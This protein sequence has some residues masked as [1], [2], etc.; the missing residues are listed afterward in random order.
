VGKEKRKRKNNHGGHG[1]R[2]YRK[3]KRKKK[4]NH[5]GHGVTRRKKKKEG[6]RTGDKI[7]GR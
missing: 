7:T 5:G 1:K 3:K 4:N 6:G 2:R